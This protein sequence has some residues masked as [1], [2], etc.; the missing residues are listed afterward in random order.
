MP[1]S[2][3]GDLVNPLLSLLVYTGDLGS[4]RARS[5][6][7]TR[8]TPTQVMKA[9]GQ[10][11]RLD[12]RE[13]DTIKLPDGLGSVTFD[14]IERWNKIQISR[15]PGKLVA[16]T[17]VV[18][19]LVGLLGSLFIRPRRVWVRTRRDEDGETVVDLGALDRSNGGDPERGE[20]ELA[21]IM[22]SLHTPD[23]DKEDTR[24]RRIVGS[25]EQPGG[26]GQRGRLLPGAA[27][28]PRPVG[29]AAQAARRRGRHD[30]S[31][32]DGRAPRRPPHRHRVSACT[33]VA[34]ARDA[35][36]PRTPTGC[37]GETCTSSRSPARSSSGCSTCSSCAASSS[38]GWARSSS[39]SSSR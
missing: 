32:G 19:A 35:G 15:T 31:Y 10:P 2:S 1:R 13:G 27:R 22:E 9:D 20:L 33:R 21:G 4:E 26:R 29:G 38:S 3:F 8:P 11:F 16:L 25:A 24:D 28:A 37:R 5:T 14:G 12:M 39:A 18:M 23:K 6:S 30:G 17:G 36:W 7:S 34:L